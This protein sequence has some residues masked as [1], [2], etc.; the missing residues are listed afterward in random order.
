MKK[1]NLWYGVP[2]VRA[3]D[4]PRIQPKS[5]VIELKTLIKGKSESWVPKVEL[6]T[7]SSIQFGSHDKIVK[8]IKEE[9]FRNYLSGKAL[10][11]LQYGL[12]KN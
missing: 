12:W 1:K 4:N 5:E 2:S 8:S 3:Y 10:S 9:M 6:C 7:S 11:I